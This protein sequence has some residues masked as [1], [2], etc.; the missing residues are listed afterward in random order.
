[1]SPE[2]YDIH[3][4]MRASRIGNQSAQDSG[5]PA[6]KS[7]DSKSEGGAEFSPAKGNANEKPTHTLAEPKEVKEDRDSG[8]TVTQWSGFTEKLACLFSG[9]CKEN[10]P[11]T[12]E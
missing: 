6:A 11:D 9:K 3:I 4:L 2:V 1:M 8:E 12:K 5:Q 10:G 7:T